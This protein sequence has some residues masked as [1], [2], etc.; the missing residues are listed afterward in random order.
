MIVFGVDPG[1]NLAGLAVLKMK[2]QGDERPDLLALDIYNAP[3]KLKF[4][5]KLFHIIGEIEKAVKEFR[6]DVLVL[7][8]A[9]T[10]ANIQSALRLAEIRGAIIYLAQ[11]YGIKIEHIAARKVKKAITGKGNASKESVASFLR[12]EFSLGEQE[13]PVD[14]TDAL[15]IAYSFCVGLNST[16][17]ELES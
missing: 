8:E 7:E 16:A 1:S 3:Q 5:E 6:P 12:F 9:F 15:G 13:I 11:K 2:P 14:A 10:G 4:D 17:I